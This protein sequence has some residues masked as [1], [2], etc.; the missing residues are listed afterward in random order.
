MNLISLM[1]I[2]KNMDVYIIKESVKYRLHVVKNTLDV[3]YAMVII[4]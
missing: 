2:G 4:L 3:D 1:M